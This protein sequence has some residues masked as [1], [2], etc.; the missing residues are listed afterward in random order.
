MTIMF[1]FARKNHLA[2]HW[3]RVAPDGEC[4]FLQPTVGS[5]KPADYHGLVHQC[6]AVSAR[7]AVVVGYGFVAHCSPP[8]RGFSATT[9]VSWLYLR[10]KSPKKPEVFLPQILG[11]G[12][13]CDMKQVMCLPQVETSL[14]TKR[15]GLD[16]AQ[17]PSSQLLICPHDSVHQ[18][19]RLFAICSLAQWGVC[20]DSMI[21]WWVSHISNWKN[22]NS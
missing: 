10:K 16:M 3:G 17:V 18:R 11:H 22:S 8:L 5:V 4:I 20:Q 15:S 2:R 12:K 14:S 19:L 1:F 9:H 21:G 13:Y 7:A 6:L